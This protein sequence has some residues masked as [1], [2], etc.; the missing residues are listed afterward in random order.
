[1]PEIPSVPGGVEAG[2]ARPAGGPISERVAASALERLVRATFAANGPLARA[3][4]HF[5]ARAGQVE[6]ALAVARV[7]DRG[8][9]LLA[10]AGTGT[11][12]TIAYL[13]PAI[14][15]R[16][17]VLVSTGTKNLQEQIFYKDLPVLRDSLGLPFTATYMKGRGNYLCLHRFDAMRESA[18]AGQ[19]YHLRLI[20]EWARETETGD[21]AEIEDL[22]EDLPL[23]KEISATAENC[24]GADCPRYA[25]CFVTRM[26]QRAAASDLVI[27]NHHLLCA[28]AAVRKGTFGE[29]IP[30]CSYA[31]VDEAH[32]LEDVA[33]Q[34]FGISVSNYRFDDLARDADRMLG[35]RLIADAERSRQVRDDVERLRETARVFFSALHFVRIDNHGGGSDSRIRVRGRQMATVG[36]DGAAL[37]AALEAAGGESILVVGEPR[38]LHVHVH[39]AD[40]GPALSAGVAQ[41]ELSA[42]KVDNMQAQHE[43]W[44]A[45]HE[46]A[47]GDDVRA[48]VDVDH[49][50]DGPFKIP[51]G[52]GLIDGIF[53]VLLAR[54]LRQLGHGSQILKNQAHLSRDEQAIDHGREGSATSAA[55]EYGT[56]AGYGGIT[57]FHDLGSGES[58]VPFTQ[59]ISGLLPHTAYHCRLVV[60]ALGLAHG[61]DQ[62]FTTANT[63]P[64]AVDD[65]VAVRNNSVVT[66]PVLANDS[67]PDSPSLQVA[68]VTD[69][70]FG[71]LSLEASGAFRY[72]PPVPLA[73]L[74][75]AP[76]A[77]SRATSAAWFTTKLW[78][79]EQRYTAT[80][81]AAVGQCSGMTPDGYPD[82]LSRWGS[83]V[84][85][86]WSFASRFFGNQMYG[87]TFSNQ[88]ILQIVDM[89]LPAFIIAQLELMIHL[90][91]I[92]GTEL[93]AKTAVHANVHIDEKIRYF[94]LRLA[95]GTFCLHDPD[96]LRRANLRANTTRGTAHFPLSFWL[97]II[98]KEGN[99]THLLWRDQ[100]FFRILD[101]ENAFCILA[102]AMLDPFFR[103]ITFLAF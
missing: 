56:G 10:E 31:I 25:D 93:R 17:R 86:R 74:S 9:A 63:P 28:D 95:V 91:R 55:I 65:R 1:M 48:Q 97:L 27:V 81:D 44:A 103:V 37:I 16:E 33:T 43:T 80:P 35:A 85:G 89:R 36:D 84:F 100:S 96:T 14:L 78:M 8:G 88:Q 62:I 41:G 19:G 50:A 77:T 21:R 75:T 58:E 38:A 7:F 40:P 34:Y 76:T 83:D 82:K 102:G 70:A 61:P 18:S 4:P 29:V 6:M 45:G 47:R 52:Q 30:S 51:L 59:T 32:Q 87:V 71:T 66:I 3:I 20:D 69:P 60:R 67:D 2:P 49:A 24:L 72:A 73:R 46:Q 90:D 68:K 57:A 94:R 42:V 101:R 15:K 98:N 23:W 53:E 13:V 39:M 64:T 99:E 11:G 54:Q 26:R 92:K 22:P 12:K 5:E 79:A